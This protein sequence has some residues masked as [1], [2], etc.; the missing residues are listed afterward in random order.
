MG[1]SEVGSKH[2]SFEE[3]PARWEF[4]LG[5]ECDK[6]I[7]RVCRISTFIQINKGQILSS[8][9]RVKSAQLCQF[10]SAE[11]LALGF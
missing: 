2:K 7:F 9:S 11:D 4:Y 8:A 1:S 6:N 3:R 5:G 10:T